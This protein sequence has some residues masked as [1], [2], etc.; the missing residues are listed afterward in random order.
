LFETRLKGGTLGSV[1]F[2]QRGDITPARIAVFTIRNGAVV[3]DGVVRVPD[4]AD[5]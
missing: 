4:S 5:D 2:D 3:V 1:S